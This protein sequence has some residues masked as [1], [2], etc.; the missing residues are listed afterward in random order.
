MGQNS[1]VSRNRPLL[2]ELTA[3]NAPHL[4]APNASV[5][6]SPIVPNDPYFATRLPDDFRPSPERVA[7]L[8]TRLVL[9]PY[10]ACGEPLI[11]SIDWIAFA[12]MEVE[13]TLFRWS[14]TGWPSIT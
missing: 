2:S 8:I 6:S 12:G 3:R 4:A 10:S 5:A 13:N 7:A 1:G 14:E 11:T 9:S